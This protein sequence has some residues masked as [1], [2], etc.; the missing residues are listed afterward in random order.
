MILSLLLWIP[1]LLVIFAYH[2]SWPPR[3]GWKWRILT[4]IL[5]F[6]LSITPSLLLAGRPEWF[7][8]NE[9]DGLE[10]RIW[11]PYSV[12][13]WTTATAAVLVLLAAIIRRI[14]T[15]RAVTRQN[16]PWVGL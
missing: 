9:T 15:E 16:V 7:A 3:V 6:V 4:D 14:L 10:M 13:L 12:P 2:V 8:E 1:L 11:L 5:I